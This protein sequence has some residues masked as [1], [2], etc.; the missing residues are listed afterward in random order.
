M[1]VS[2]EFY[3]FT[4]KFTECSRREH[5]VH[6]TEERCSYHQKHASI[7]RSKSNNTIML[8]LNEI[9]RCYDF[10]PSCLAGNCVQ[11]SNSLGKKKLNSVWYRDPGFVE[12]C[13]FYLSFL[14]IW[15]DS[16]FW[17]QPT[18]DSVFSNIASVMT[19]AICVHL[20]A[21]QKLIILQCT[22]KVLHI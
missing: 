17:E 4:C 12:P 15:F 16:L 21:F 7:K 2:K 18:I 19:K 6:F 14:G 3:T 10:E 1:K 8:N 20:T 9:V 22:R 11:K 13:D 5:R